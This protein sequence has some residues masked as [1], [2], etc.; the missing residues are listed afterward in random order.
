[1]M[2]GY[3]SSGESTGPPVVARPGLDTVHYST[4]LRVRVCMPAL[5]APG[6]RV[7]RCGRLPDRREPPFLHSSSWS[8]VKPAGLAGHVGLVFTDETREG[9]RRFSGLHARSLV[10]D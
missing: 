2:Y 9:P 3:S 4:R 7:L 1:M 8:R 6:R 5:K 10:D